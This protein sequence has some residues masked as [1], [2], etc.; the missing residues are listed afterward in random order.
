MRKVAPPI[1]LTVTRN[2][3]LRPEL[4]ADHAEDQRAQRPKGEAGGEQ[5]ERGDQ[6]RRRLEPGEE[7]LAR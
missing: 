3:P 1:R 2:A 6:R 7:H 5:G 4:V